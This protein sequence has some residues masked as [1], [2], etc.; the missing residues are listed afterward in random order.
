MDLESGAS[1]SCWWIRREVRK[2]ASRFCPAQ[3]GWGCSSSGGGC[4]LRTRGGATA[5][6]DMSC[7]EP[8]TCKAQAQRGHRTQGLELGLGAEAGW[9]SSILMDLTDM[10]GRDK[11][12]ARH[13]E[14][15]SWACHSGSGGE[16]GP[17]KEAVIREDTGT[18][19][20]R[21]ELSTHSPRGPHSFSLSHCPVPGPLCMWLHLLSQAHAPLSCIVV[22]TPNPQ[23]GDPD[24]CSPKLKAG[25][26]PH[27]A[28]S[29]P[30][31]SWPLPALSSPLQQPPEESCSCSC[32]QCS[33]CSEMRCLEMGEW[34]STEQRKWRFA[35]WRVWVCDHGTEVG[36]VSECVRQC[37][38]VRFQPR[39]AV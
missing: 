27:H 30:S 10:G 36:P 29:P 20:F 14:A 16:E 18:G 26:P 3:E 34:G 24:S 5:G 31:H 19:Q 35:G 17:G 22:I 15:E 4:P 6:A 1:R 9:V 7:R 12:P 23:A 21:A 37:E 28:S 2:Q 38:R 11:A 33:F 13:R 25:K 8:M 32:F 39:S